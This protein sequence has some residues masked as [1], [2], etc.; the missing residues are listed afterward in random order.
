MD[1]GWQNIVH[2][3]NNMTVTW[4]DTIINDDRTSID[5]IIVGDP[6]HRRRWT[7][8]RS[9]NNH[10]SSFQ[11]RSNRQDPRTGSALTAI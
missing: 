4:F 10:R 8:I 2:N 6:Q 3:M 5:I 7:Y 1:I 9:Q 11:V